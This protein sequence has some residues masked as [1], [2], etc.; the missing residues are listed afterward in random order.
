MSPPVQRRPSFLQRVRPFTA[1]GEAARGPQTAFPYAAVLDMPS[2]EGGSVVVHREHGPVESGAFLP[3]PASAVDPRDFDVPPEPARKR[4]HS[5]SFS[6][7]L[8]SVVRRLSVSVKQNKSHKQS[9]PMG[10]TDQTGFGN[11]SRLLEKKVA[12]HGQPVLRRSSLSSLGLPGWMSPQHGVFE[13]IPGHRGEPPVLPSDVSH[14][15]AARA[16]AA[17]QNEQIKLERMASNTESFH[18]DV[19]LDSKRSFDSESGIEINIQDASDDEQ[20]LEF[21]RRGKID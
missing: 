3:L 16:A 18:L 6:S 8:R 4:H 1:G 20:E 21:V 10:D 11:E 9:A 2:K 19:K 13:P 12:S 5:K 14:G 15:A 17:A 7:G